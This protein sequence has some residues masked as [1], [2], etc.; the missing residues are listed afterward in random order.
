MGKQRK[1]QKPREGR[2]EKRNHRHDKSHSRQRARAGK[3]GLVLGQAKPPG[4]QGAG[5]HSAGSLKATQ[6]HKCRADF[7]TNAWVAQ[8]FPV[9]PDDV[10]YAFERNAG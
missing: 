3:E 5:R 4:R 2:V 10:P 9:G 1:K 7:L 6:L 8:S